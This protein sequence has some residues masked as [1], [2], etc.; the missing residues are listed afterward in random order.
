MSETGWRTLSLSDVKPIA[1]P[2]VDNIE[3]WLPLRHTL[4]VEAFGV[5]AWVGF[6]EGDE[7]IEE[8]DELNEDGADNHEELYLVIEGHATFTVDG[9]EVDAPRGTVVFVKDPAIVR[10]AV[11]RSAGT[12]V[13]AI[14]A[15]P[16]KAFEPSPWEQR[17]IRA[18]AV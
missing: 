1:S 8:H 16:G 10:H 5:N 11:A 12:T 7:V 6:E 13:L 14:G 2:C 4:G 15:A 17:G 3:G 18:A 9:N